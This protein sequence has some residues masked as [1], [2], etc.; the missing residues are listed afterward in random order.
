M[1][2]LTDGHLFVLVV[3]SVMVE[4]VCIDGWPRLCWWSYLLWSNVYALMDGQVCAG[5]YSHLQMAMLVLPDGDMSMNGHICVD[6][7]S[8]LCSQSCL[9]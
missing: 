5:G 8:Y 6:G 3:I 7:W 1:F 2:M 9:C 4:C